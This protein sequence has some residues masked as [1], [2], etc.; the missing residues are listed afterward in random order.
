MTQSE[1]DAAIGFLNAAVGRYPDYAPAHS[2]L[3]F[4]LLVSGHL[5]LSYTSGSQLA[6][7]IE[8]ATR[9]AE[10]DD[11]DP[12][13]HLAL[14]YAAFMRRSTAESTAEFQR[15]LELNPNFAA[16]H[17]YLG[18][19]LA[20]D[21]QSDKAIAHLEEAIR[22]SPHDPQNSIF[23][24]GIAIGHYLEARYPQAIA[25]CRKAFQ[26]RAGLA[27]GSRIYIASLAQAGQLD[28]ARAA[29]VRVKE[30]HPDLS[31]AW[32]ERN[33]PYTAAPMAKFLEGMRKAGLE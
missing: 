6:R 21:G 15:A 22:M 11:S 14:G 27:R 1:A 10:L 26:Q 17:G 8:L 18:W 4:I 19:A 20:F 2:L 13:A 25:T 5:N 30:T 32:I 28:E 31:I 9:A 12:W 16:A 33:V 24:V 29:L 3:A 7:A 23:N